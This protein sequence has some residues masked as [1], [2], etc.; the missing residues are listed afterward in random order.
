MYDDYAL[1]CDSFRSDTALVIP[2]VIVGARPPSDEDGGLTASPPKVV[3]E[4]HVRPSASRRRLAVGLPSWFP[5][6]ALLVAA[7]GLAG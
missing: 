1:T 3:K 5:A 4:V 2:H 6:R 7:A